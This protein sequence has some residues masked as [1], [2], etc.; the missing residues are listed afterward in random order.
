MFREFKKQ[1]RLAMAFSHEFCTLI[2]LENISRTWIIYLM[3]EECFVCAIAGGF[4]PFCSSSHCQIRKTKVCG[5]VV[6]HVLAATLTKD[7]FIKKGRPNYFKD[8]SIICVCVLS[9]LYIYVYIGRLR[10]IKRKLLGTY[11]KAKNL[12]NYSA[13]RWYFVC[14]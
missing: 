4:L 8:R 5:A 14:V 10:A 11:Y 13:G 2:I 6:R 12:L 3:F 1:P 9:L 7:G